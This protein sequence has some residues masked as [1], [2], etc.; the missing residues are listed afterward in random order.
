ML[1]VPGYRFQALVTCLPQSTHPPRRGWRY[2][3]GW[4]VC[5]NVNKELQTEFAMACLGVVPFWASEAALSLASLAYN[6][7]VG[8][9]RQL[10][11]ER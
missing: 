1:E 7:V 6:L 4:A 9:A 2:Y 8:V 11:W 5:E 10:G 3:T